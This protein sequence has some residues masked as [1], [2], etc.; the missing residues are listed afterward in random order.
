MRS[1][2]SERTSLKVRGFILR[3]WFAMTYGKKNGV[4]AVAMKLVHV[5][6]EGS[7]LCLGDGVVS[8][9]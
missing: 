2:G 3:M 5:E 1:M 4:G 6:R 9:D 8:L 7:S